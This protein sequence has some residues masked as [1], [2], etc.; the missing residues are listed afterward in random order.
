MP[1]F[2]EADREIKDL[3]RQIMQQLY[4][5]LIDAGVTVGLLVASPTDEG[6]DGEVEPALK[7]H[8]YPAVALVRVVPYRD[9]VAGMPD[10][11]ILL[12]AQHWDEADDDRRTA[13]LDHE[14]Y[15]LELQYTRKG[16]LKTDD[17]RR[18]KLKLKPH[19][20]QLGGFDEIVRRN[21]TSAVEAEAYINLNRQMSQMT[22]PWG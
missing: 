15:H 8:G 2:R 9:R 19:D 11:Q 22:F 14:L 13:I 18:P 10:A 12:D 21:K 6:E 16:Q 17:A 1:V 20:W 4:Q 3:C 5:P 7:H